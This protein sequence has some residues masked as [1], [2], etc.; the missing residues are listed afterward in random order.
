MSEFQT[1]TSLNRLN[2][3]HKITTINDSSGWCTTEAVTT[4]CQIL[5]IPQI[6]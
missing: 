6:P 3:C 1:E 2:I 4:K 5:G